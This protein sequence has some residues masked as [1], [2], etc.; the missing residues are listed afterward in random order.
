MEDRK[1]T[2]ERAYKCYLSDAEFEL[3]ESMREALEDETGAKVS[4]S[5]FMRRALLSLTSSR[6]EAASISYG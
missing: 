3:M 2:R 4:R 1:K 6:L 5:Q